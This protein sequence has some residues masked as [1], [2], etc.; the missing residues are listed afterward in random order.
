MLSVLALLLSN[1]RH[2]DIIWPLRVFALVLKMFLKNS[3]GWHSTPWLHSLP[4]RCPCSNFLV[5]FL[6]LLSFYFPNCTFAL[7]ACH[8]APLIC[9]W[10]QNVSYIF[11]Q[12]ERQCD[13]WGPFYI[14]PDVFALICGFIACPKCVA[15]TVFRVTD[16]CSFC[17]RD[18]WT[19][20]LIQLSDLSEVL[21]SATFHLPLV[22]S[23]SLTSNCPPVTQLQCVPDKLL[24]TN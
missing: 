17:H 9:S 6:S 19:L 22:L 5:L 4:F 7:F 8:T 15:M 18:R 21:E 16:G 20:L 1:I 24:Q 12:P 11:P 14:L 13:T 23:G 10:E 2:H 3:L